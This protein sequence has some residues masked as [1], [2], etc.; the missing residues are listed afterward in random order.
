MAKY[1]GI[2][3]S[4]MRG[5]LGGLVAS[6][7]RSGVT[8]KAQAVPRQQG[9]LLQQQ[10]KVRFAAALQAWR[11]MTGTQQA[12]WGTGALA[13]LWTNS[14][15]TTYT[16]TGLQLWQQAWVNAALLSTT[17]PA[18]YSGSP[19][20][21][22]PIVDATLIGSAGSYTLTVYPS[23][24][25]YTGAWVSFLSTVIPQTLNYTKT[26]SRKFCGGALAGDST[27]LGSTFESIWGPLP[28]PG[29]YV[30]LRVVP[31]HPTTFVSG[32][33]FIST[34]QFTA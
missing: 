2:L 33:V 17:P 24:G 25:S 20:D 5:K 28:A 9:T 14:L 21:I 26:L 31:V 1:L 10:Q 16:P 27:V 8:L 11:A 12:G 32:T 3:T 15:G 34:L 30:S 23:S 7:G 6:R 19:S 29:P 13:L 4:D 18:T 22:V